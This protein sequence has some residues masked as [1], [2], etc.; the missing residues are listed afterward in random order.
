MASLIAFLFIHPSALYALFLILLA[1]GGT[2]I[3]LPDEAVLI[4]FGYLAH[5]EFIDLRATL[6]IAAVGLI[7]ADVVGYLIGRFAGGLL[8][9]IVAR[10]RHAAAI[11]K[12]AE[13]LFTRH[14]D[15]I[16]VLSRPLISVRV[17]VPMFAGHLRMPLRKFLLLDA[18]AA[19]PWVAGFVLASYFLGSQFDLIAEVRSAKHYFFAVLGLAI[20]AFAGV[21]FIR[22]TAPAQSNPRV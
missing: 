18:L 6:I 12:K 9:S 14:G 15:K 10:S 20:I 2:G 17:A 19:I 1:F 16:I 4:F 3:S 13:E 5:L 7:T 22:P 8:I 21:R 11:A